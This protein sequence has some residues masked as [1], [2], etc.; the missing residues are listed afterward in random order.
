[1][2]A[3]F[4]ASFR[5]VHSDGLH[6][7]HRKRWWVSYSFRL[8]TAQ[9]SLGLPSPVGTSSQR[10]A[11]V[12]ARPTSRHRRNRFAAFYTV[13]I[14]VWS[15]PKEARAALGKASNKSSKRCRGGRNL[16]PVRSRLGAFGLEESG[17]N[18]VRLWPE[19][20]AVIS[21]PVRNAKLEQVVLY[22]L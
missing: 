17:E 19:E 11:T 3:A 16:P 15:V 8:V 20:G 13:S 5:F 10:H 21:K 18:F 2:L 22:L 6:L 1:M 14:S 7:L 9:D 4:A 12:Y